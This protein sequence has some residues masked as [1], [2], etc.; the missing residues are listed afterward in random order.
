[1]TMLKVW[2][3]DC[4][5]VVADSAEEAMRLARDFYGS[6]LDPSDAAVFEPCKDDR[7]FTFHADGTRATPGVTK[8]F[9]EWAAERGRGYFCTSEF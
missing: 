9:A 4:D 1:M 5:Y 8:T 7:P 6:A 3:N 2:T